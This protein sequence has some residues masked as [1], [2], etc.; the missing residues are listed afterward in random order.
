MAVAGQKRRTERLSRLVQHQNYLVATAQ[1]AFMEMATSVKILTNARK[2]LL[3]S[4][5]GAAAR[6]H[7]VDT[8]ASVEV[9]ACI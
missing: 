5:L 6:I 4:A 2:V 7:G 9:I 1:K 3:V 8:V